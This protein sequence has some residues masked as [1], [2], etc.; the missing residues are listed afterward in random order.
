MQAPGERHA[1]DPVLDAHAYL[2]KNKILP[3][4][5]ALTAS[6]LARPA[7]NVSTTTSIWSS[8][9]VCQNS[10]RGLHLFTFS[11]T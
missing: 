2:N 3:I 9:L 11:S 10:K 5:E 6:I 7:G 4:L 8:H 1:N